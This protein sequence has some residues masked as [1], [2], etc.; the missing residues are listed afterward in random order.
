MNRLPPAKRAHILHLLVEGMS[1]RAASRVADVSLNTVYKLLADAG[2]AC[3]AYHDEHVRGVKARR[4]QCDEI[5]SFIY[6][7]GKNVPTAKAPPPEA[8]D[9]W[10]WTALE[11]DTKLMI[12]YAIG[13]RSARTALAFMEDLRSRLATRVQLTTD[14]HY[15]YLEAVEGAFDYGEIDYAQLVKMY[16]TPTEAEKRYSPAVCV[17]ARKRPISGR[18]AP[19]HVSTSY[20]E[21]QNLTMRMG[22]RR[23]TRLT[24]AFSKRLRGHLH[25]CSLFFLHY[26]F[27]RIHG[28]L[29]VSP[30]MA[31]GV[32]GEL[33]DMDWMVSL[34]PK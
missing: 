17:G 12:S 8:G 26:N 18:P 21:R 1:L 25:M 11:A 31:A 9:V 10:T 27:V 6:A 19:A 14:G 13:D 4:V 5:W 34:L 23:F 16:G 32:T 30:A 22:M 24:N 33:R 29:G 28:T 15:A 2:E 7:K 3:A 20:V